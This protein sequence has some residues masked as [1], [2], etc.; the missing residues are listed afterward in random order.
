VCTNC[1]ETG[2]VYVADE[3]FCARCALDLR[4]AELETDGRMR[5]R[6]GVDGRRWSEIIAD[7]VASDRNRSAGR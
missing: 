1:R 7:L 6:R 3:L 2:V 4:L 5:Q